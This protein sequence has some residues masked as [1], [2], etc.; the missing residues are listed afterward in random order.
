LHRGRAIVCSLLPERPAKVPRGD[1][2]A[3]D[4]RS[5]REAWRFHTV[6]QPGE[7][8]HDTWDGDS[9]KERTGVNVWSIMS[10]DPELG[11]VYLPLGSPAYDFYGGDRKGQ[12]LFG[13]CLASL[14]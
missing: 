13:N 8:G 11:R 7:F 12:N 9:W 4:I 14:A 2:R 3:F 1:V 6:P 5:G 10:V